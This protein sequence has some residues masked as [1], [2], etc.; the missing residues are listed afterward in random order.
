MFGLRVLG[1]F[2]R[3]VRN[4]NP[5]GAPDGQF[6]AWIFIN[7]ALGGIA[8]GSVVLYLIEVIRS[9]SQNRR[10]LCM[11]RECVSKLE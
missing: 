6:G 7:D 5:R 4:D 2:E 9:P 10:S 3:A 11:V 8:G 1:N